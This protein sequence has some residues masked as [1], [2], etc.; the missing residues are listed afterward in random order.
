MV[1]FLPRVGINI[2]VELEL[3]MCPIT[4]LLRKKNAI[5][6]CAY[7]LLLSGCVLAHLPSKERLEALGHI[8][9]W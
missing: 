2:L 9:C 6:I 3:S 5:P 8:L 1:T 4:A 7:S